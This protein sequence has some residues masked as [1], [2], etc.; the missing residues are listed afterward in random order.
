MDDATEAARP[1]QADAGAATVDAAADAA[2]APACATCRAPSARL[3]ADVARSAAASVTDTETVDAAAATGAAMLEVARLIGAA[4]VDAAA[5]A[6]CPPACAACWTAPAVDAVTSV[7]ATAVACTPACVA[8]IFLLRYLNVDGK[9]QRIPKSI[10]A[11]TP[12]ITGMSHTGSLLPG[13]LSS[14]TESGS[15]GG[16]G[17]A[18]G[19][20]G[21]AAGLGLIGGGKD[22]G[23]ERMIT[24]TSGAE[25]ASRVTPRIALA[26][27]APELTSDCRDEAMLEEATSLSPAKI[28][29]TTSTEPAV[30]VSDT[31]SGVTDATMASAC[32]NADASKSAT[33]PATVNR[34]FTLKPVAA[35]GM[36]RK[37]RRRRRRWHG[38]W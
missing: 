1:H 26:P 12:T 30:T 3:A 20:G 14:L 19:V 21:G 31:L 25:M 29:A 28:S 32:A 4:T 37:R 2:C 22:G 5:D 11:A 10:T 24:T 23:A 18:G 17:V 7:T 27:A 38:G 13:P 16:N 36:R 35:P 15:V 8:L 34:C 9:M 33:V 6:A